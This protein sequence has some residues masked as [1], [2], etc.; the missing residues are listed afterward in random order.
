ME[1]IRVLI[2]ATSHSQM[3]NSA[4]KTGVWL[5]EIAAPYYV[6][7]DAGANITLASPKGGIVPLDPK[8]E[9]I[10]VA[11]STTRKFLKDPEAIS[12]IEHS[13]KVDGLLASD[14]DFVF[15]PGG[16]G[17]LWDFPKSAALATLLEEFNAQKKF[18]GAVCH[19][20]AGLLAVN[21]ESGEPLVK[22]RQLTCF[23]NSEEEI[24]GLT[25]VV[26]FLLESKL[27]S[28]G[29]YFTQRPDFENHVVADGNLI[30]GQ[31]PSSSKEVAR[32]LLLALKTAGE[33]KLA[34]IAQ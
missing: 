14:F 32:R 10:I 33:K 27:V 13:V 22:G 8:S 7:K 4:R 3:G 30:T 12:W 26:P 23:S 17:P 2:I 16:H 9:S 18:I 28:L 25:N 1:P 19:G 5:E 29:A 24:S 11:N 15:L 34:A 21:N 6:F 31:N 20:V